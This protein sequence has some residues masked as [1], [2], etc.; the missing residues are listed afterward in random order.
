M[1][2]TSPSRKLIANN[3]ADIKIAYFCVILQQFLYIPS[4]FLRT[5]CKFVGE[6]TKWQKHHSFNSFLC[7]F[8]RYSS[9]LDILFTIRNRKK[10]TNTGM[11]N[12]KILRCKIYSW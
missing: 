4:N 2:T 9:E 7:N 1:S 10:E 3:Y 8:A 11:Q 6:K 12:I 5:V